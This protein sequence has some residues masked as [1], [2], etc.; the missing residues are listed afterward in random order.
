MA[1]SGRYQ[2]TENIRATRYIIPVAVCDFLG[3]V[4][5][6]ILW[7]NRQNEHFMECFN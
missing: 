7:N 1:L 5:L 4:S 2:L 6:L 3:R